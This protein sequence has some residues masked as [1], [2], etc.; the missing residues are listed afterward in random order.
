MGRPQRGLGAVRAAD[1]AALS[2]LGLREQR[3]HFSFSRAVAAGTYK[4]S[5]VWLLLL[6]P[7]VWLLP[8]GHFLPGLPALCWQE[9]GLL[10]GSLLQVMRSVVD[11]TGREGGLTRLG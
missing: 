6:R 7:S 11:S 3:S 4:E 1:R 8:P 10:P 2:H 5:S 9:V